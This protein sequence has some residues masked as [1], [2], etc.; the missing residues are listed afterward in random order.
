MKF[1]DREKELKIL[2]DIDGQSRNSAKMT[3]LTGRR[4]VGK[5]ILAKRFAEKRPHLYFFVSKKSEALLCRE[6]VKIINEQSK[7]KLIGK[8]DRFKDIFETILVHSTDENICIIIDEFQE[9]LNVN[10]AAYSELQNLWDSY[11]HKSRMNLILIGSVYSLMNRIFENAKEPLFGRADRFLKLK[12]FKAETLAGILKDHG[13]YSAKNLFDYYLFT[14]GIPRYVE[15]L[16][17]NRIKGRRQAIE[18]I[19]DKYSPFLGEGKNVLIEEFG[20][21]YGIYFSILELISTGHTSRPAMESILER[22]IGGHL[23]RLE[24]DYDIVSKLKPIHAKPESKLRR[25]YISDNFL[26]F[27]F[28]FIYKNRSAAE[29]ENFEYIRQIIHRDYTSYS[30]RILEKFFM[31]LLRSTNRY[32]RIGSF[33]EK[34]NKYEI[35]IVAV[36]DMEK[37]LDLFDVKMNQKRLDMS[38]LQKNSERLTRYFMD[39]EISL[40]GLSLNSAAE[41]LP[42][43][44]SV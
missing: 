2:R 21:E 40:H 12:P 7:I 29:N 13:L 10:P 3:V 6:F 34:G 11:K 31:D 24:K 41:F 26:N 9:F 42:D 39:Y 1:Y 16:V 14:G 27:W 8:F 23:K 15:I 4:R 20:K 25:Y 36:N 19:I 30:G 28:R 43:L 44:R 22:N 33:W 17:E 35:D 38:K 37:S 32:N 5:T 18:F